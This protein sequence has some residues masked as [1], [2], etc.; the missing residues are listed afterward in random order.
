MQDDAGG[1]EMVRTL[2]ARV[3]G[4]NLSVPLV[5]A[6][7]RQS[8]VV[9]FNPAMDGS[10]GERFIFSFQ[11][12][13]YGTVVVFSLI[14]YLAVLIALRPL[15][16]Y[17]SN[18]TNYDRARRATIAVPW[19]LILMHVGLWL[20]G[21][22]LVYW[23]AYSWTAPGGVPYGWALLLAGTSGL[24]TGVFAAVW[25]GPVLLPAKERLGMLEIREG[26]S[27]LFAKIKSI[28]IVVSGM[29]A[30]A[31]FSA[32]V[33][34]FYR[35]E[36]AIPSLL[37]H[38]R[39]TM[40]VLGTIFTAL[41]LLMIYLARREDRTQLRLLRA[42]LS[43][44]AESGG[45][46]S[47]RIP[48]LNFDE[49]GE[50]TVGF[51]E[52]ISSIEFIVQSVK[53]TSIDLAE[54]SEALTS[55]M[56]VTT[57]TVSSIGDAVD[58][59]RDRI[60][61]EAASLDQSSSAMEQISRSLE[62][63]DALVAEQAANVTES[64]AA[65]GQM[66]GQIK[67][68]NQGAAE[69]SGAFEQLVQTANQGRDRL[70]LVGEQIAAVESQSASLDEANKL[71]AEIASRTNLL[72]MNAA[73]EAA[74]AGDAGKGFAVVADEIR[75]LAENTASQSKSIKEQ[76]GKT[77]EAITEVVSGVRVAE[78]A[79]TEVQTQIEVARKL[80]SGVS[81]AMSS[82]SA[83]SE[84]IMRALEQI[85]GI[86]EQ[87][88]SGSDEMSAGASS[89]S[90]E[91]T[92]LLEQSAGVKERIAA[93]ADAAGEMSRTVGEALEVAAR[94]REVAAILTEQTARFR[95]SQ[96]DGPPGEESDP[97]SD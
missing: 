29:A 16:T 13:V 24:I 48:L 56:R 81:D 17:L 84:Q 37:E 60:F 95:V 33:L 39:A 88:R 75:T 53:R 46:L 32:Y 47:Q 64:S 62:S 42:R 45:D 96:D 21:T 49:I 72:A 26:D 41:T 87:V 4:I 40:I 1:R 55:S 19:I 63:L 7:L 3:F 34:E 85:T 9:V 30:L 89:V 23:L 82:V 77:T 91:M 76:L 94:N 69:V 78:G 18:Q 79:F 93:I 83:S 73:I 57:D 54:T 10:V 52:F 80:E 74:H 2:Q 11:A 67:S 15:T 92:K 8:I 28:A 61:S 22:T 97:E 70:N 36:T 58:E 12:T 71:I 43:E 66:V 31:T 27:D 59:I 25:L 14:L 86:T 68:T 5:F 51:N 44:L 38:H 20:I 90:G 65:I 50:V 6:L 35:S